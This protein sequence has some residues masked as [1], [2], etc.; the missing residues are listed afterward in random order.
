MPTFIPPALL[1]EELIPK[2]GNNYSSAKIVKSPLGHLSG[3]LILGLPRPDLF[4]LLIISISYPKH[5]NSPPLSDMHSPFWKVLKNFQGCF[6]FSIPFSLRGLGGS[7]GWAGD[8][9]ICPNRM[10]CFW[11]KRHLVEKT[12]RA[13]A[14]EI[15]E[16]TK[17]DEF[18]QRWIR[19][20]GL[21]F[22][23]A[24]NLI[25]KCAR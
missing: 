16:R 8:L 11:G 6:P 18:K 20:M 17:I 19:N 4:E 15:T 24:F 21:N 25:R 3:W 23:E 13:G 7:L 22:P 1:L 12:Q 9:S 14:R 10:L 5:S 2:F